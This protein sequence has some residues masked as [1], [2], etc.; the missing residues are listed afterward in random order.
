MIATADLGKL[1]DAAALLAGAR[2]QAVAV[3]PNARGAG[4]LVADACGDAGLQ[5]ADLTEETQRA[6]RAL[7]PPSAAVAGPVDTTAVIAPGLFRRC[8]E[9]SGADPGVDAILALTVKTATSDLVPE[10]GQCVPSDSRWPGGDGR[11]VLLGG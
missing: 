9:L 5:V 3:V 4:V 2:G 6:L 11:E 1:L 8:L 10:L 7:L